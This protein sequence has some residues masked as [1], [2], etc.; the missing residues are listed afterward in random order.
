MYAFWISGLRASRKQSHMEPLLSLLLPLDHEPRPRSDELLL[1]ERPPTRGPASDALGD[2]LRLA[3]HLGLRLWRVSRL[4]GAR[5]RLEILRLRVARQAIRLPIG[6]LR[7]ARHEAGLQRDRVGL[8]AAGALGRPR[9]VEEGV[10]VE[11]VLGPARLA[12]QDQTRVVTRHPRSPPPPGAARSRPCSAR[13][14]WCRCTRCR[15]P[16]V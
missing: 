16:R 2:R 4:A 7:P 8:I 12:A 6:P 14:A 1:A 11:V 10:R 5:N 15:R 13:R 3:D 9:E